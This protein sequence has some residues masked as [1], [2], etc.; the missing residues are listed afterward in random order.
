MGTKDEIVTETVRLPRDH[1]IF[2][3]RDIRI[4]NYLRTEASDTDLGSITVRI[5]ALDNLWL[6]AFELGFEA[7]A[8]LAHEAAKSK[9]KAK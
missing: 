1:P 8:A 6:A 5:P 2:Q 3:Q 9:P 7:G 4:M